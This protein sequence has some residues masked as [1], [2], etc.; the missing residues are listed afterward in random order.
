MSLLVTIYVF[1]GQLALLL[2]FLW[3]AR[4]P[5]DPL[6][7]KLLPYRLLILILVVTS[8]STLAHLIGVYTGNPVV[9]R[10]KMGM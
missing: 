6:K 7:P 3:Q 8:L 1:V 9:V 4:K 10:R 2:L 5:T